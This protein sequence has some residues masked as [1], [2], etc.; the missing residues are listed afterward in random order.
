M[1]PAALIDLDGV[2]RIGSKPA[3]DAGELLNFIKENKIPALI[4]SNSSLKT[5]SDII[6]YLQ[7]HSIDFNIHAVTSV[8]V[9]KDYVDKN[10]K[11]ISVYCIDT[12]KEVFREY[13]DDEKPEA[14]L[15]GDIG[16]KWNFSIMN[17]IFRK[18][19]NG[20]ELI[21]LHK[22]KFWK[23][24]GINYS[25]DAGAFVNAIEYAASKEALLIGKPSPVY[26]KAA[27]NRLGVNPGDNFFMIGDDIE[28]DIYPVHKLGGKG[29]LVYT[30][31]TKHPLSPKYKKPSYEASDLYEVISIL[32]STV[33]IK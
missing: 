25:L 18:V 16:D 33:G 19:L 27:L 21:A 11:R 15:I 13:L 9:A 29:I 8:D 28:N 23:P 24:D 5:G 3:P 1:F 10:F 4:L 6:K 2:L 22:N 14:V 30:G 12:I 20:A 7:S 32:K 17:E 26:F 31:K